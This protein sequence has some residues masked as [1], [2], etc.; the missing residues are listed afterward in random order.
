MSVREQLEL[1]EGSDLLARAREQ[2]PRWAQSDPRLV[3]V[4]D[5]DDLRAWLRQADPAHADQVLLALAMLAAPD[6]GDDLVA[7][8]AL[9]HALVPGAAVLAARMVALRAIWRGTQWNTG[10]LGGEDPD[11]LVA[12]QLW[13]EV[14]SFPWRRLSHVASNILLSTRVAVLTEYGSWPQ[15]ERR[16]RTW[17]H[18]VAL[19]AFSYGDTSRDGDRAQPRSAM[20]AGLDRAGQRALFAAGSG[21]EPSSA[22]ELCSVLAWAAE[23]GV[24]AEQDRQLLLLMVEEAWVSQDRGLFSTAE[25]R[26]GNHQGN[27]GGFTSRKLTA[28]VAER[29]GLAEST[30]RRR[31][32]RCMR[33]LAAASTQY[34]EHVA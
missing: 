16:D 19:E 31:T 1:G 25:V 8:G 27:C 33:A 30:V 9:A 32:S 13:L 20:L 29:V 34:P 18:T 15:V 26:Q 6:G 23:S 2:W 17:A 24:I 22:E 4:E 10:V 5:F 14:R 12:A 11:K 21:P 28:R 3:V 7:A